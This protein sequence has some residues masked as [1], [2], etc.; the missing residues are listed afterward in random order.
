MKDALIARYMRMMMPN[1]SEEM[2]DIQIAFLE[3]KTEDE[4]R[5]VIND[6]YDLEKRWGRGKKKKRK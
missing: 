3:T 5:Q 6:C 2:A 1:V 4:L